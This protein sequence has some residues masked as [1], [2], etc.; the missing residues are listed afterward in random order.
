MNQLD[1]VNEMLEALGEPHVLALDTGGTSEE[2]EA[3]VILDREK[4]RVLENGLGIRVNSYTNLAGWA[5]NSEYEVTLNFASVKLTGTIA[6]SNT[7]VKGEIVTQATSG[8][9]GYI[10]AA[11][12]TGNTTFYVCPLPDSAAFDGSHNITG[13]T[14]G[15]ST[16]TVTAVDATLT[17][18]VIVIP[19]D[20]IEIHCY[21]NFG[22]Q[23]VVERNGQLFDLESNTYDFTDSVQCALT[24]NLSIDKLTSRLADYVVKSASRKFQRFKKRGVVDDQMA[25][26]EMIVA[27]VSAEQEHRDMLPASR[28]PNPLNSADIILVKGDRIRYSAPNLD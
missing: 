8:A 28:R 12:T 20:V 18:G 6:A 14:S 23:E 10:A 13:A 16:A 17:S 4:R 19:N 22:P 5:C 7:F 11:Y 9:Q 25:G 24:R 21:D 15:K 27:K 26:E 2:A 3:E 1:A